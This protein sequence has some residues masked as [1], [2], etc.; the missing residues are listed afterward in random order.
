[1]KRRNIFLCIPNLK[2]TMLIFCAVI[3][4]L[5]VVITPSVIIAQS[6]TYTYTVVI[7]AGHGGMDGGCLGVSGTNEADL[8]LDYAKTLQTFCQQFGFRVVMTRTNEN[9]LYSSF[10]SNKKK[11]DMK[12]R[13]EIIDKSGAN[14][15]VSIHMN[16]FSAKS[17]RGAQVFYYDESQSSKNLADNIQKQYISGLVKPRQTSQ[18]ADYY[19]LKC[20]SVP[21]VLIECGFISNKEEESL[22]LS[23]EYREKLCYL[24]LCGIVNFLA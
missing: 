1:M 12:K 6:K 21:S 9:G 8:N 22:L 16:S 24:T 15:V 18:S 13:K 2:K 5:A 23:K 17:S 3:L 19:I 7:D 4:A 20:S 11:D 14:L 10:A